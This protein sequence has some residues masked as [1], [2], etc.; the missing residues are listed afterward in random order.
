MRRTCKRPPRAGIPRSTRDA[1]TGGPPRACAVP[2]QEASQGRGEVDEQVAF[3]AVDG[4]EIDRWREV[5]QEMGIDLAILEVLA[6]V[7][8]I[9]PPGH[10]PID[11]TDAV[12]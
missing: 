6:H 1:A 2:R 11:V 9:E 10:V 12:A 3:A 7:R 8:R 4:A 5:Q